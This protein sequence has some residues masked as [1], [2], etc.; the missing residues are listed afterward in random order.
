MNE[1]ELQVDRLG[2][3]ILT[4]FNVHPKSG[5]TRGDWRGVL[6]PCAYPVREVTAEFLR[7]HLWR[8][9]RNKPRHR[10]VVVW[11][12]GDKRL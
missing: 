11:E 7:V 3:D 1:P 12:F 5:A 9:Q 8:C 10:G 4:R 6:M 2:W